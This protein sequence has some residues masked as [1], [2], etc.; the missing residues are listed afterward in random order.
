MFIEINAVMTAGKNMTNISHSFK[1]I[2]LSLISALLI[3]CGGGGGG[4]SSSNNS[5]G[6]GSGAPTINFD[7]AGP[8]TEYQFLRSVDYKFT[9]TAESPTN[10]NSTVSYASSDTSVATVNEFTGEVTIP[11]NGATGTTLISASV[12]AEGSYNAGS[13][14]YTLVVTN[15]VPFTA[16]VGNNDT[17]VNLPAATSGL[18]FYSHADRNCRGCAGGYSVNLSGTTFTDP[19]ANLND[20]TYYTLE[21]NGQPSAPATVSQQRF[22]GR[23]SH[24]LISFDNKLWLIGG[25]N[26][27]AQTDIWS[28]YNGQVWT[29]ESSNA[30]FVGAG[31]YDHQM[32]NASDVRM[33]LIGGRTAGLT[34]NNW[35]YTSPTGAGSSWDVG[36]DLKTLFGYRFDHQVSEFNGQYWITGGFNGSSN[37]NDTWKS[38]D[39]L[40][41]TEVT[42]T[43]TYT[44]RRQHQT[45][46]F[47][48]KL[49]LIGGHDGSYLNDIWSFDGSNWT[50]ETDSAPFSARRDHKLI[51][52][53]DKLWLIGGLNNLPGGGVLADIW[54]SSNG[55][56]W[57]QVTANAPFG[58]VYEHSIAVF[59]NRLWLIGGRPSVGLSSYSNEVWS[60]ADGSNW[61]L[62]DSPS[63]FTGRSNVQAHSFA[64]KLWF[65]GG[66]S[67]TTNN[68][69]WSST[70]GISW[71]EQDNS[72]AFS[73]RTNHQ[74]AE[75][76]GA[77]W[78]SGG[79]TS[80][81]GDSLN[82]IWL[83][84]NA[85]DWV[86]QTDSAA[87]QA[88]SGHQM[89]SFDGLLWII[90]GKQ[91]DSSYLDD[92]WSSSDGINWTE[93][94]AN[95][96]PDS[97]GG[98]W[99]HQSVAYNGELWIIGGRGD[100]GL[101][102]DVWSF[103]T[104]TNS[105]TEATASA[106]FSPR[107]KHQAVAFN[108]GS[109][110]KLFL[111]GG[112]ELFGSSTSVALNDIWTSTNGVDWSKQTTNASFP[113]RHSHRIVKHDGEL[114]LIG[115]IDSDGNKL[116]DVWK[117]SD[118]I[119]W[120]RAFNNSIFFQ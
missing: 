86:R 78:L 2:F 31:I 11:K 95:G 75:L 70:N 88:R 54:S 38:A 81:D 100:A 15:E 12:T 77:L 13:N 102:N 24:K 74:I 39:G 90:G 112:E 76:N 85:S 83:S 42:P 115:G 107:S 28:S 67:D 4:G 26:D 14:S 80:N 17:E 59:N 110:E 111:I 117:S 120:R 89:F 119:N 30:F 37:L 69:I 118:G 5:G 27:A 92:T 8:I 53:N 113:A 97:Y 114:F 40:I 50:K 20:V 21:N 105:W 57:T 48:G 98:R 91:N 52:F 58:P 93:R 35:I 9:N 33:I 109:G 16:W 46:A 32:I 19:T 1:I 104:Q 34:L 116:K 10:P 56:E 3:A 18:Q 63:E 94:T 84:N 87:F 72:N 41:W 101:K 29:E 7:D 23:N 108:D 49:W 25:L 71:A 65:F 73:A 60:S 6:T 47:N 43:T 64:D 51:A 55:T 79:Q 44:T 82:D 68:D 36:A 96:H 22:S 106:N 45:A 66:E 62:E 61:T 99:N 103:N